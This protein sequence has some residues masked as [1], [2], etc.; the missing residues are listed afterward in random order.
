MLKVFADIFVRKIFSWIGAKIA[1]FIDSVR[2]GG[3]LLFLDIENWQKIV[4]SH[5]LTSV[6]IECKKK[7][8][9]RINMTIV[10]S[11]TI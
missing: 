9:I 4:G 10:C 2:Y 8:F 6:A 5:R 7:V 3:C 1:F 11:N